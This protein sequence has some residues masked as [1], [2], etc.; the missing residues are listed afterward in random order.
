MKDFGLWERLVARRRPVEMELEITARCNNDC[1]HCYINVPAGDAAARAAELS[2]PEIMA[3]AEEAAGLGSVW[4]VITGGEPL[5]REDF[6]DIY[7]GLKRLGLLVTVFTNACLVTPAHVELFLQYP[8]R[9]VEVTVYGASQDTYEHVTRRP[10]SW[11]AFRRGLQALLDGGVPVRLKAMVMRSNVHELAQMSSFCR[12]HTKDYYRFDPLLHF[13][14]DGAEARNA[15]IRSERLTPREIVEVEQSD[16]ERFGSLEEACASRAIAWQ[17]ADHDD[18]D[19]LL[20]CGAGMGTF[21]LGH[22]GTFKLCASLVHG[23]T[24]VSVR[25]GVQGAL[26]LTQAWEEWA[27][28]VLTLKGSDPLF[29]ERCR[30][31]ALLNLCLWCPGHALLETGRMD[32]WV[33]YFCA[34]AHERAA[35]AGWREGSE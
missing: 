11:A 12:E 23:D 21:T 16:R 2:F 9:D 10:G 13:R 18:C 5:L 17:G 30:G 25:P 35:A 7:L 22:D 15:D 33:E 32:D 20:H 31:C 24:V 26:S 14:L 27:P 19:H 29:L 6:A 3:L 1:R 8:P 28:R 34:V 4:C